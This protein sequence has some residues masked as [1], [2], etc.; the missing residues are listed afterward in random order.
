MPNKKALNKPKNKNIPY[1]VMLSPFLIVFIIFMLIPV[2]SI[3]VLS[4]TDFNMLQMPNFV[5]ADNYIRLLLEDQVFM[6]DIRNTLQLA[7]ITGPIGF[8]LSFIIAWLINEFGRK[9]RSFLTLVMYAPALCGNVFFVWMFIFSSDSKGLINNELIKMG[10]IHDPILWLSDPKY[11]LTVVMIVTLWMS[12]GVG[13][14]SFLAGLQS[15]DRTFYEAAAIDGLKNR[16]QELYYV[17]FPQMGPQLLFGS[18]MAISGAF[19]VGSINQAMTGFPSTN[20]STDT[21]VLHIQDYA[22]IR[23]EMGYASAIAVVLFVMML[24]SWYLVTKLLGKFTG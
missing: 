20:Y 13:F 18:V 7:L 23:F 6:I 9:L 21:I 17:T 19:A 11:S 24:L 14:L 15:L 1:Y 4:F 10:I 16:W 22:S 2:L 12:F 8:I 5:G 3:I